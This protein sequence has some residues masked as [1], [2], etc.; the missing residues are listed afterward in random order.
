MSDTHALIAELL[1]THNAVAIDRYFGST[2]TLDGPGDME[3]IPSPGKPVKSTT[4]E[5]KTQYCTTIKYNLKCNPDEIVLYSPDIDTLWLGGLIQ[6]TSLG[7]GIGSFRS[8]P[9]NKRAP[10]TIAVDILADNNRVTVKNPNAAE[11]NKAIGG[12]IN[13]LSKAKA[14]Y[15][16]SVSFKF[17]ETYS[18]NQSLL[19]L[20]LSAHYAGAEFQAKHG[21]ATSSEKR[22][23][24]VS[25]IEK[26]YTVFIDNPTSPS[27]L[28]SSDFSMDD[29]RL[30]EGLGRVSKTNPPAL[31]QIITYGRMFYCTISSTASME[32]VKSALT[33]SYSSSGAGG[34]GTFTQA[35]KQLLAESK[36]TVSAIGIPEDAASAVIRSGSY[37]ELLSKPMDIATAK[38]ISYIFRNLK[39]LSIAS[40]V[41]AGEYE[42]TVCVLQNASVDAVSHRVA[43]DARFNDFYRC[44]DA[45][46]GNRNDPPT[47]DE[48]IRGYHMNH[49][50]VKFN[51][52]WLRDNAPSLTNEDNDYCLDWLKQLIEQMKEMM[53]MFKSKHDN[54]PWAVGIYQ[55]GY[56][57]CSEQLELAQA[58]SAAFKAVP[59]KP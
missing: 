8:L 35:Q 5:G 26:C 44:V 55:E 12:M 13:S 58:T 18:L 22:V 6:G 34:S 36:F 24:T 1:R 20:G 3:T 46:A 23:M 39:D 15:G 31:L 51:L 30:Q 48:R 57:E 19:E 50:L 32:E 40:Y 53:V 38:P 56:N 52:R 25:Y 27:A 41:N 33:A 42:I 45:A 59:R 11:V 16:T 47:R 43:T 54:Q 10:L 9:F 28:F 21:E 49:E 17:C 29:I 14:Q 37:A 7:K 4:K 2:D